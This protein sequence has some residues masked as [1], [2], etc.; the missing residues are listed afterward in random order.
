[1]ARNDELPAIF[2]NTIKSD[3]P[4]KDLEISS[5]E[6]QAAAVISELSQ[7]YPTWAMADVL[8]LKKFLNQAQTLPESEQTSLIKDEL[9]RV[10]HDIKGQGGTF[11]YPLM[12]D[13]AAQL[14]NFIK[15][16]K[17]FSAQKMDF[18]QEHIDVLETILKDKLAGDGGE[19]G[20]RVWEKIKKDDSDT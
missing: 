7:Q 12:T 19:T 17:N 10:S 15:E 4:E 8:K 2:Q 1:M 20:Q 13:V 18:I 16:S 3:A 11:G 5:V 6:Q 14:C 9:Y